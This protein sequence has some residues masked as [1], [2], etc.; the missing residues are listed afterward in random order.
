MTFNGRMG[1]GR[2]VRSCGTLNGGLRYGLSPSREDFHLTAPAGEVGCVA[3]TAT[4]ALLSGKMGFGPECV[5]LVWEA[6]AGT[7]WASSSPLG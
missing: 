7:R 3:A 5:V 6:G 1:G 4:W 2:H